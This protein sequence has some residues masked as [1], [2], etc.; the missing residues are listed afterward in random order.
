MPLKIKQTIAYYAI[1]ILLG[2]NGAVLGPALSTLAAH[3]GS[4]LSAISII[5]TA[6]SAGRFIGALFGARL[7]DRIKIGHRVMALGLGLMALM[8]IATPQ[9]RTLALLMLISAIS[10]FAETLTDVGGN[11]L[12]VWSHGTG[13]APFMNGLH[14]AFG[15]GTFIAPFII[16]L[17]LNLSNDVALGYAVAAA[18]VLPALLVALRLRSPSAE[19]HANANANGAVNM[20]MVLLMAA[21][22][23]FFVGVEIG[24]GNWSFNYGTAFGMNTNEAAVLASTYWGAFTLGRLISIPI[25][26]RVTPKTYLW[27]DVGGILLGSLLVLML[28]R[29]PW[30]GMSIVGLAVASAFPTLMAFAEQRMTITGKV[31]GIFLAAANLSGMSVPWLIGQFFESRGPVTLPIVMLTTAVM[32][33][34][35]LIA[36]LRMERAQTKL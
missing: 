24:F 7:Y 22:C 10:G 4:T 11:T 9:V 14:F 16:A 13:V 28:P 26:T 35:A 15:V 25:A 18:L 20:T 6:G 36:L 21:V 29:L 34:L 17:S 30:I 3:T 5:F 27:L 23:F 12:L 32:I 2:A 33:V 31:T 19:H 8:L 1:F